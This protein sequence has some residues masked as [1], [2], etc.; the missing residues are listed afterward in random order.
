MMWLYC[1]YQ[2][3]PSWIFLIHGK[4]TRSVLI[5]KLN[6]FTV[7]IFITFRSPFNMK[8]CLEMFGNSIFIFYAIIKNQNVANGMHST[9][10]DFTQSML[11]NIINLPS[12][13]DRIYFQTWCLCTPIHSLN[14]FVTECFT[15]STCYNF[16]NVIPLKFWRCRF[17]IANYI[18]MLW[19][20]CGDL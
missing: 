19:R 13:C 16:D 4:R 20:Y 15:I 14:L 6:N 5:N 17:Q 1:F 3:I 8:R 10:N 2:I 7:Y 9:Q 12:N 18:S 11:K